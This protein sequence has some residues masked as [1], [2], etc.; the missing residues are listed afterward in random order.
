MRLCKKYNEFLKTLR[1]SFKLNHLMHSGEIS[2][3]LQPLALNLPAIRQAWLHIDK[4]FCA[5]TNSLSV[6]CNNAHNI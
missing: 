3:T 2:L 5:Q 4:P 1:A 6:T